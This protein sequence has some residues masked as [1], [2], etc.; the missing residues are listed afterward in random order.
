MNITN[1]TQSTILRA[2]A[3]AL[4]PALGVLGF[5]ACGGSGG[6]GPKGSLPPPLNP[7]DPSSGCTPEQYA[8]MWD[9]LSCPE[10][11][12][13]VG[14][15]YGNSISNIA[16]LVGG[17]RADWS[18][19]GR[20]VVFQRNEPAAN[21]GSAIY[22]INTDGSGEVRLADGGQPAWS[23]DGTRIA[24]RSD[25]GIA[26]MNVDGSEILTLAAHE[27]GVRSPAYSAPA[28]SPEGLRIVFA[29]NGEFPTHPA[30]LT[31]MSSDGSNRQH[32][33]MTNA[34]RWSTQDPA[35][36]PN[37]GT[38]AFF[39]NE[40]LATIDAS[41]GD[42]ETI[43]SG[44]ERPG[45]RPAW[46]PDGS[47]IS[48]SAPNRCMGLDILTVGSQGGTPRLQV[49]G[50]QEP[51]WSSDGTRLLLASSA[52]AFPEVTRP[53]SVYVREDFESGGS[54]SR[55]VLFE[56]G[57][58]ELQYSSL[59][60]GVHSYDGSYLRDDGLFSFAFSENGGMPWRAMGT[61]DGNRLS[62]T[63]NFS[64][65]MAGFEDGVY[66]LSETID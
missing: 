59:Q 58:F 40:Q 44:P 43:V 26:V 49:A 16:A 4:I 5:A 33:P 37:G 3:V 29:E 46:S 64:A 13:C 6:E 66:V 50:G 56:S 34:D 23:P 65:N 17:R 31:I 7:G 35:W 45:S 27:P 48:W 28:W 11:L 12:I 30:Q 61:L 53:G 62:V 55:Y 19:D 42:A 32:L 18:P 41:G 24:F 8:E 9:S 15:A 25:A 36:S 20:M 21:G 38:I 2:L 60:W 57:D 39:L 22:R 14:E 1:L 10:G 51:A 52:D 63:Y 47:S 54:R